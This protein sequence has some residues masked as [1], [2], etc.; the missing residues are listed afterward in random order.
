MTTMTEDGQCAP[1]HRPVLLEACCGSVEEAV[2]ADGAG[3]DRLELCAGLPTGG[4]TPSLGM[5][6]EVI[7]RVR[8]PVVAMV[9]PR[10]GGPCPPE[11]DFLA[12]VRDVRLCVQHGATEVIC[13]VLTPDGSID[14]D[15]NRQLVEAADG[16][17]VAFHRVFDMVPDLSGALEDLIDLGFARVLTSGGHPNVDEGLDGLEQLTRLAAG[18]I[19]ILAGGG[20]RPHNARR[21]VEVAGC[22]E[23]HFSFRA[24]S[25]TTGYGGAMDFRPVPERIEAVRSEVS[26]L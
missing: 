25:G 1:P 4:V 19:T 14:R 15:R 11:A 6:Q 18:R 5:L 10:E 3:A 26:G 16:R 2:A 20:V 9:R 21:L 7:D 17:P 12:A 8:I 22:R 24:D 13:G 23:L